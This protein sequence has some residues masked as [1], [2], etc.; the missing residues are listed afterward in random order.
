LF[1]II[2]GC[3]MIIWFKQ[4]LSALLLLGRNKRNPPEFSAGNVM[5]FYKAQRFCIKVQSLVLILNENTRN[6]YFHNVFTS[7]DVRRRDGFRVPP[8]S[9]PV[10]QSL[11]YNSE[12]CTTNCLSRYQTKDSS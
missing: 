7:F 5:L 10:S 3:W 9:L 12:P 1:L 4:K 6:N 2:F 11:E 8:N